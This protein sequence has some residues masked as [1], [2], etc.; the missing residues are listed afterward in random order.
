MMMMNCFCRMVDRRKAEPSFQPG[1][2]SEILTI[3]IL[4]HAASRI[5][6]CAEPVF[7]LWLMKLCSSDNH[8]TTAPQ[9]LGLH[10]SGNNLLNSLITSV[11]SIWK[12]LWWTVADLSLEVI[13]MIKDDHYRQSLVP[14]HEGEGVDWMW[15]TA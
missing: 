9:Y 4:R 12:F 3:A 6:T 7:R 8:Y 15:K 5:W 13:K 10:I 11:A 1:A 2:L 14:S